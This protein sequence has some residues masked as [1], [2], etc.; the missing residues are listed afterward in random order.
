[1]SHKSVHGGGSVLLQTLSPSSCSPLCFD[2]LGVDAINDCVQSLSRMEMT[3]IAR[4]ALMYSIIHE[5][6]C[7]TNAKIDKDASYPI[8]V[9]VVNGHP[10]MMFKGTLHPHMLRN[11]LETLLKTVEDYIERVE[12]DDER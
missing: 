6:Y 12:S 1:M 7:D 5:M 4:S 11:T 8:S 10:T 3:S 2:D 9:S